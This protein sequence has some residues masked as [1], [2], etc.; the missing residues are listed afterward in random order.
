[1]TKKTPA[2]AGLLE[3][4]TAKE[5]EHTAKTEFDGQTG[6]L[7]T[8]PLKTAPADFD[9]LLTQFG[10]DPTTVEIVGGP[11]TSRWQQRARNAEGEFE[12]VWL[13]A[14]KFQIRAKGAGIAVSELLDEIGTWTPRPPAKPAKRSKRNAPTFV[15]VV[16]DTQIGKGDGDGSEGTVHRFLESVDRVAEAYKRHAKRHG[17]SALLVA[18]V[19]DCLEGNVS[20]GGRLVT[21]NDLTITEQNRVFRRLLLHAA[22]VLAPLTPELVLGVVNGNHD[23]STRA[24][25]TRPDDG[26]A[27]ESAIAVGD[28][29]AL[30]DGYEHV[31][32]QIPPLDQ[33]YMTI[34][35]GSS[36]FTLAHGHQWRRGK[37]LDW[38]A[39]HALYQ[40]A[41]ASANFLLHGHYHTTN[42]AVDGPRTVLGCSTLDGGSSWYREKTGAT[43][44]TGSLAFTAVRSRFHDLEVI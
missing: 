30:T 4:P 12:V 44:S 16:G 42:I 17:K 5:A 26:W 22:K 29:L 6:Y 38:W 19:G 18:V 27:T 11:R 20:Q 3:Q 10:Y 24:Y 34:E 28:A 40:G 2:L 1:M 31:R 39:S 25:A 33:G 36:V 35:V 32:V 41:P 8:E 7:A 15:W 9:A 21:R 14:Y 23:E 43:N 37:A 13:T